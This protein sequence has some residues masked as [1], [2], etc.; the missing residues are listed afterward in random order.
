MVRPRI[1]R[2][3]LYAA[4]LEKARRLAQEWSRRYPSIEAVLLSGGVSRGY[5]DEASEL[6]LTLFLAPAAYRTWVLQGRS[7]IPEGDSIWDGTWIDTH[8]TTLAA[9]RRARWDPLRVW[10]ASQGKVLLDRRG[11][12]RGLL[13]EKVRVARDSRALSENWI[14]TDW[15]VWLGGNWVDRTDAVAGHHLLNLAFDRFLIG[16][17]S[18]QGEIPPFDKWRLHLSR[19]LARLPPRY[20]ARVREW[21]V[22]RRF[23]AEDIAR[24]MRAA[25]ALLQWWRRSFPDVAVDVVSRDALRTLR[26]G[27]VPLPE[28][29][30]RFGPAMLVSVPLRLVTRVERGTVRLDRP[31]L[32]RVLRDGDP[33]VHDWQIER[34]REAVAAR[35]PV[36]RRRASATG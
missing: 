14:T 29:R 36:R 31:A 19:S 23:T 28:F 25:S 32:D 15:Y 22:V 13:R 18:A 27:P 5:A 6:D 35:R 34:F 2:R 9:A 24:R 3:N 10:D 30:R 21:M 4:Y 17:F 20:E 7:P 26:R 16:L 33:T 12:L 8:L 1:R 11:R